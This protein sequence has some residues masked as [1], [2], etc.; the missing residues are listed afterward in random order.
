MAP[1]LVSFIYQPDTAQSHLSEFQ[2]QDG[3]GQ[4]GLWSGLCRTVLPDDGCRRAHSTV[5]AIIPRGLGCI[6]KLV[7]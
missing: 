3:P 7:E 1:I 5:Y 2:V 4:T 6:R